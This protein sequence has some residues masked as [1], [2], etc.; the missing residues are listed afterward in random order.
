MAQMS[1]PGV[2]YLLPHIHG[3]HALNYLYDKP[4]VH[5][6]R[7]AKPHLPQTVES[8]LAKYDELS[9]VKVVEWGRFLA[10]ERDEASRFIFLLSKYGRYQGSEEY[11]DYRIHNYTDISLERSWS[12]YEE[13]EPLTV[14]YDGGIALRGLALGQGAE[15]MS[16]RQALELGRDRPLWMALRWQIA[17]GLDVDYAI[18][19]RLH[20]AAGEKIFQ[21]DAVLWNPV[22]RPTSNWSHEEAVDTTALLTFP[23]DLP[24]G[25]YE[26]RMVVYDFETLT[27][28]VEIGVWEPEMTLARLRLAEVQ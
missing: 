17:P 19:L 21:E 6:L 5:F 26:L 18:S 22:H 28:T 7:A 12:F 16:S 11:A 10:W 20:D 1:M 4:S 9:I 24:A 25:E 23:A 14:D 13:L 3:D 2:V 15:Q 8:V 27:P